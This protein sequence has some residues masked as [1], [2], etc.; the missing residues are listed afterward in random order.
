MTML[1]HPGGPFEQAPD[2]SG[3]QTT[4]EA[5]AADARR[6][7]IKQFCMCALSVVLAVGVLA[8]I[9]ALRAAFFLSR[10]NFHS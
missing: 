3:R 9:I 6:A 7:K 4:V 8:G 5:G 2:S 1:T 10:L